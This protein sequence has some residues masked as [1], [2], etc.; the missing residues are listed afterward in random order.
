M[1]KPRVMTKC[2]ANGNTAPNERIVEFSATEDYS[3][4]LG[5]LISFTRSTQPDVNKLVVS[6]YRCDP[7]VC[8]MVS[9]ENLV[10]PDSAPAAGQRD[11]LLAAVEYLFPRAHRHLVDGSRMEEIQ[12]LVASLRPQEHSK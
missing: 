7:G 5:G 4:P 9:P 8:V 12:A 1:A 2:V 3:Q 10:V 6:V 11:K